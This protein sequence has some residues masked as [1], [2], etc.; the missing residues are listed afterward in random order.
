MMR[1]LVWEHLMISFVQGHGPASSLYDVLSALKNPA[2]C[3]VPRGLKAQL[4]RAV[5]DLRACRAAPGLIKCA[6]DAS[7][8]LHRLEDAL[9][10]TDPAQQAALRREFTR[11]SD[12][13]L[14]TPLW[15]E[16]ERS[17]KTAAD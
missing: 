3:S 11:L 15:V 12:D 6:Q 2:T 7:V 8:A 17:P 14:E 13:W 16:W 10:A 1:G 5:D 4:F 9:R